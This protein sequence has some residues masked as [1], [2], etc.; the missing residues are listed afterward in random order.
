MAN[1]S[2]VNASGKLLQDPPNQWLVDKGALPGVILLRRMA[3]KMREYI[4]HND[5]IQISY[6]SVA[7]P[8]FK[9]WMHANFE[10]EA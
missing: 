4:H 2:I 7:E 10:S 3:S 1:I 6:L 5:N 8:L 9:S